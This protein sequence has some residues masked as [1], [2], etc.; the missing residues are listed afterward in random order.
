MNL[1]RW[2]VLG[3][4]RIATRTVIPAINSS[5]FGRVIAIASRDIAKAERASAELGIA[6]AY[7][8]YDE[9]LADPAVDAVYNPLPNHLHVPWSI[10]AM[11][12]GKHVLCEKPM[13]MTA[14]EADTL[15][16]VQEATGMRFSEAFM[17]RSHPR[18]HAVRDLIASNR[19][20]PLRLVSAH[21]SYFRIDPSD[22]RSRSEWGGGVLMDIGC[23]PILVARWL[24]G[25]EPSSVF[26]ALEI[27][28]DLGVDRLVS[29]VL[30]FPNGTATFNCAGQLFGHQ[31]VSCFGTT[32]RIDR[33][34]VQ[35]VQR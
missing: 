23:Y 5:R 7:G 11:E 34:A 29:A 2:G 14:A 19:I 9:L 18:W 32:G 12:A 4:A 35:S 26:G 16:A 6:T 8:S 25:T 27:D 17:V 33:H 28:P 30:K 22:V 10:K 20:E 21:F 15:R 24:F 3:V 13:A 1:L 31:M